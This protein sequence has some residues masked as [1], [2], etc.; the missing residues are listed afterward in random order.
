MKESVV[1]ERNEQG[2]QMY[3]IY[4]FAESVIAWLGNATSSS[5]VVIGPSK[6]DDQIAI[7]GEFYIKELQLGRHTYESMPSH[8]Q[9]VVQNIHSDIAQDGN[10]AGLLQRHFLSVAVSLWFPRMWTI[11]EANLPS[12][13]LPQTGFQQASSRRPFALFEFLN[14]YRR[15]QPAISQ[16]KVRIAST[17]NLR[18]SNTLTETLPG[19]KPLIRSLLYL[20]SI[21]ATRD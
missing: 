18:I 14:R 12:N 4:T 2:R 11:Q 7:H 20:V 13:L 1:H 17:R 6:V 5:K 10:W 16:T 3:Q 15:P 19:M 8:L 21:S 9:A